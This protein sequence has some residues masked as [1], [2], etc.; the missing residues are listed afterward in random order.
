VDL[1]GVECIQLRTWEGQDTVNVYQEELADT[2]L[3]QVAVD[4][5]L[6]GGAGD[7]T[8]DEVYVGGTNGNDQIT[9]A[10]AGSVVSVA[11]LQAQVTVAHAEALD[12][13]SIGGGLGDDVITA[14]GLPA[15][16]MQLDLVGGF[17]NDKITGSAG[18]DFINGAQGNDR[19]DGGNGIDQLNGGAGDDVILGGLG[20]DLIDG[21]FG[22]DTL[23][24]G[25]GSDTFYYNGVLD[26]LDV[27][28]DFDGDAAGGQDRLNLD[29]LFDQ[30][31]VADGSRAN[32]VQIADNGGTVE[33]RVNADGNGVNGFELHVATLN[34]TDAIAVHQD[35]I[36]IG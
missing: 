24:G 15:G 36:V 5:G 30:L 8:V 13:L 23:T 26:G 3:K 19:L 16:I 18:N 31:L 25:G 4:L 14:A 33:V 35:I 11:G 20:D 32:L 10:M 6:A 7:S 12:L 2:D 17:G 34:T 9:I 1:N 27:I 29:A 28:L 21:N 22:D